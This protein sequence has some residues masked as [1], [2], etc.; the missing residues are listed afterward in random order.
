MVYL[1]YGNPSYDYQDTKAKGYNVQKK[2]ESYVY[3]PV[4]SSDFTK[5]ATESVVTLSPDLSK[6][7]IDKKMSSTG[8]TGQML[9]YSYNDLSNNEEKR[10][11]QIL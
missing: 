3:A 6:V 1:A 5:I 11:L 8:Y 9:R 2:Q 4:V 10:S 7:T